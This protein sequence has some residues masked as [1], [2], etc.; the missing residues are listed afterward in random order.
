VTSG[1]REVPV[2]PLR[3]AFLRSG[4]SRCEV[5]RRMGWGNKA[6]YRASRALGLVPTPMRRGYPPKHI[7]TTSYDRAVQL[8]RAIGID[9]TDVG[10]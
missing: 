4:L 2:A 8:A 3:E 1:H 5:A 6:G 9:P 7:E 10:L